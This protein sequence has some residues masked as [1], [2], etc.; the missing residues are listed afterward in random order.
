METRIGKF[1]TNILAVLLWT[2]GAAGGIGAPI[3]SI[4]PSPVVHSVGEGF[5]LF[6]QASQFNDLYAYQFNVSFDPRILR[7]EEVNE[8]T[9]LKEAGTT[10]FIPGAINNATGTIALT[11]GTLVGAVPGATGSGTLADLLF[12]AIGTGPSQVNLSTVQLL[13][14]SL[15]QI[16]VEVRNGVVNVPEPSTW[17]LLTPALMAALSYRRMRRIANRGAYMADVPEA[18]FGTTNA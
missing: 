7:V 13:D 16:P 1:R 11:G 9:A 10:F 17:F 18:D 14:S 15:T 8:G 5:F 4:I 2:M 3:V 6:V 12:T